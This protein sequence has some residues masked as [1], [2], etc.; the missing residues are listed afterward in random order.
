MWTPE[1]RKNLSIFLFFL[2]LAIIFTAPLSLGPHERAANDGDPLHISWILAWDAHQLI[3][4][5]L[6]LFDSNT[7]Y[8]YEKSL[9][10]SE[11]F[12][13]IALFAAPFYYLTG[14]ALFAHNMVLLLTIAACGAAMFWLV[15]EMLG[16]SDAAIVAGIV[17]AF[18]TYNFHEVPRL[19]LLSAQWLPL[20]ILFLH[21]AFTTGGRKNFFLFGLCFILQGLSCTYYLF[22]FGV[23]LA[24]WLPAYILFG[25]NNRKERFRSTSGLLAPVLISGMIFSIFFLPYLQMLRDFTFQRSLTRGLDLL[26][27]I[28]PPAGSLLG[29]FISFEF[30]PSVV[31]QYLGIGA[32]VLAFLGILTISRQQ[33]RPIKLFCWLSTATI[34]I[35]IIFSLGPDIRIGGTDWGIGPYTLLYEQV[36]LFRV[37]RNAERM[38]ILVRLGVAILAGF[39]AKTFFDWLPVST[40][41]YA[42]I[43]LLVFLPYE[44][45]SGGQ[46][47]TTLPTGSSTPEVYSWLA[48]KKPSEPV[49]EL[50]LYPRS[51][52]RRHAIYMFY[53]TIHW[54]PI[55]F[56]RTSFYP[57]L[58]SYLAWEL[59]SFPSKESL[60]LLEGLGVERIVIH[61]KLW[62]AEERSKKLTR[63]RELSDRLMP[64][65]QFDTLNGRPYTKYGF[66]GE[67]VY[68]L[69]ATGITPTTSSLCLPTSEIKP[70]DWKLSGDSKT[71]V[72]W[73]IDRDVSTQWSTQG[74]LPGIKLEVDLGQEETISAVKLTLGFP[75]DNFPRDLTL[76]V[77]RP[78]ESFKPVNYQNDIATKWEL[79]DTLVNNP[80]QS[81]ITLRFNKVQ[82]RR[83]RFW[84]REGKSFDYGLPDWSMPELHIYRDCKVRP[85]T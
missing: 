39:G 84:I 24:L 54:Q 61:P 11:H 20:A 2:A 41:R 64:E 70:N 32:L 82:A 27:Y 13:G 26:E 83:L 38:S 4:A 21:R 10:F 36:P 65:G 46:F 43:A 16:R 12:V 14:N 7:F 81:A 48:N 3:R 6:N 76:K 40:L 25:N 62:G 57:P 77:S 45:F 67:H 66:G 55:V 29:Q 51:Q 58:P 73:A 30:E 75:Q 78:G 52:L 35:G 31:P 1:F 59:R 68:K 74:Q 60:S 34:L 72:K 80:Q 56:G 19:Q 42:R 17:Y 15:K 85:K 49:V 69:R 5:P 8:P 9:A 53:S 37:L 71:P 23:L 18:N 79:V 63:L 44:H 33:Q 50:P 28:R 22:Y 47:Y